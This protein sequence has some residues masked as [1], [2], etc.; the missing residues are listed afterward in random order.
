MIRVLVAWASLFA[1]L[2]ACAQQPVRVMSSYA[3]TS[4]P[5]RLVNN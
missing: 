1:T 4:G 2:L 5:T 3:A